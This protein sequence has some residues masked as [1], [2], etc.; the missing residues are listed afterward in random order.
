MSQFP[1]SRHE[2]FGP[3]AD[4][5]ARTGTGRKLGKLDNGTVALAISSMAF[6]WMMPMLLRA[7]VRQ[8]PRKRKPPAGG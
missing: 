2:G 1:G 6:Y 8:A 5:Q 4:A 3:G 7:A